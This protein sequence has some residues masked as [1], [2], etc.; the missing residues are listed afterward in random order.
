[1]SKYN[2]DELQKIVEKSLS[3]AEVCRKLNMRPV[4]G[5]YKTLKNKF[6]IFDID[7]S[8]FTGQGWNVGEN[9]KFFGRRF[10]LDEI[11]VENSTYTS[12]TVL[13]KKLFNA[14]L[15]EDRCEKCG[16]TE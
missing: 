2:K 15:K 10:S 1:M 13:K 8:H 6:K 14:G 7:T 11:L 3:I 16:L 4:G 9:F 12:T 5:N